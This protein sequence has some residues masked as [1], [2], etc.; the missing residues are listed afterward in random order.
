MLLRTLGFRV[1]ELEA[2]PYRVLLCDSTPVAY[3][4]GTHW[5]RTSQYHRKGVTKALNRWLKDRPV[6][7]VAQQQIGELFQ[8]LDRW[9]DAMQD[10]RQTGRRETDQ[11][12]SVLRL[13][14]ALSEVLNN[15]R[16]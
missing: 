1:Q 2:G 9:S 4:D 6:Q 13:A 5:F 3:T 14:E 12:K 7:E 16:S 10:R 15:G 8:G 11:P